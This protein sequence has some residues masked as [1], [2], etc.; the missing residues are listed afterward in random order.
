M[1]INLVDHGYLGR[2]GDFKKITCQTRKKTLKKRLH[3]F[4]KIVSLK[5]PSL[6]PMIRLPI[7]KVPL[8]DSTPLSPK[9][10]ST[11]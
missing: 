8:G 4:W 10:V 9:K 3:S 6:G 2:Q 1:T 11:N 5:N 7:G